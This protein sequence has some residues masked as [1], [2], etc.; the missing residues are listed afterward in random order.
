MEAGARYPDV[1]AG[2]GSDGFRMQGAWV[3]QEG[4]TAYQVLDATDDWSAESDRIGLRV[5]ADRR[6]K[7]LKAGTSGIG[8]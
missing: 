7:R 3:G 6:C 1:I 2:K 4:Y 8:V 5:P